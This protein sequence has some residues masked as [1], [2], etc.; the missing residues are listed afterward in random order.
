MKTALFHN[1]TD[2]PFTVYWNGKPQ[3][4]KAGEQKYMPEYLAEHF[5]KHLTNQVLIEN[6]DV[7][8]TSPKHPDQVPKFMELFNRACIKDKS[9]DEG[10]EAAFQIELANRGRTP[11]SDIETPTLSSAPQ[12]VEAPDADEDENS[13]FEGLK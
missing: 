9:A 13:E 12:I 5:A 8:S 6:K 2:K 7:T 3:V 11:S 1:F 4:F 10:D